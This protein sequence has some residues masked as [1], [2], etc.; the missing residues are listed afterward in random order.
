[1]LMATTPQRGTD[2]T[3]R[4]LTIL[5]LSKSGAAVARYVQKRGG[6]C[7]LSETLPATPSNELLRKELQS[8]GVEIEMGG[9]TK[10]CFTHSD[11]VVVS[12]GIPPSSPIMAQL[13]LSGIDV[14]S[15][16]ELAYRETDVPMIGITGTNGKTTTTTLISAILT[17]A[18][19]AAPTCGNIG[20]P[21]IA[22]LDEEPKLD[23]LVA[24]LSSYQLAFSPTL[25]AK[26]AVFTNFTPDH[27]DWHGSLEAYFRAKLVLFSGDQSPE[28]SVI[29]E[30]GGYCSR[31]ETYT[32]N[33]VF[34]FARNPETVKSF[35]Y[36]SY[37]NAENAF[38]LSGD[39]EGSVAQGYAQPLFWAKD[40]KLI[41]QHNY[42][43]VL[44]ALSVS[45]LLGIDPHSVKKT[46]LNFKGVE[47]RLEPVA[48][49]GDS[50]FYNDSKATNPEA[51]ISALRAFPAEPVVLIAGGRD[52][53]GPLEDF[54]SEI[55]HYAKTVVLLG[56]AKDRFKA[57]L[58]QADYLQILEASSL[59]EAVR[60]AYE[61][62][63][64][65]PVLFSP[66]C[67]SFD[68]FKNF[69]ERGQAF[70]QC[71]HQLHLESQTTGNATHK[72]SEVARR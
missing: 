15:E 66:A 6:K 24:E 17:D 29:L 54:V 39:F 34:R 35:H 27:L 16:V 31:V 71:V 51:A 56:E 12:P 19:Y 59:D 25:K 38:C 1:M 7:F 4:N 62:A 55:K 18:G 21:V 2:W 5:G 40:L 9:H 20:R 10:Q 50:V 23:Y 22:V 70:K 30:D 28:W 43:N 3:G 36:K 13:R 26:I 64:G 33:K 48:N 68:M 60:L 37:L 11:L 57:A 72:P 47:H 14:I 58:T 46:C 67:A 41:G 65:G 42:E 52:K 53:N 32:R 49:V 44:A 63:E 8:I 45:A 61:H 69:E